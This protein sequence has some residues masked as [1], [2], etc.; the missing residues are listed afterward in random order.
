MTSGVDI[1]I[2]N[3]N[4]R[5]DLA[6]CLAS[7]T[8]A[9]PACAAQVIVV[10]NASTDGSVAMVNGRWP[11]VRTIAL[12]QN[13]GFGAANNVAMRQSQ[14][15]F[16]LLLNSDTIVPAGAIDTLLARLEAT[17]AAAAGP[18]L[19]DGAGRPEVSFG[20]MLTPWTEIVQRRR[21][22]LAAHG[23]AQAM[24]QTER[25]LAQEQFVDWVS[26]ACLLLR[27]A[28]AEAAGFFDE[29][30][31]M[32]EEDVDLCAA[33]R[34][35]GGTVLF[36][37]AAQITHLRGRSVAQMMGPAGPTHYDRSHVAFYEK[38]APGWAPWLRLWLRLRGRTIR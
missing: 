36:T 2:V 17:R 13:V 25:L 5:D 32:Y 38:H 22:R 12:P 9:W 16:V 18:R 31:F 19:A 33:I 34:Q 29:R 8:D 26:G 10:D 11:A 37:P 20:S 4:T 7:L 27:R 30:Y 1:I 24:Q 6:A 14:A 21:V 15:P 23:S 28:D 3:Y 35:R